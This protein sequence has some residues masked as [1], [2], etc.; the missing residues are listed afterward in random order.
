V[1]YFAYPNSICWITFLSLKIPARRIV[2]WPPLHKSFSEEEVDGVST[3]F[4]NVKTPFPKKGSR[5][6][7]KFLMEKVCQSI[8]L[9]SRTLTK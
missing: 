9:I 3:S 7:F 6:S 1:I 2:I 5:A 8:F 4:P